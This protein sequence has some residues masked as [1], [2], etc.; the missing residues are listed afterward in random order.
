MVHVTP[1]SKC[2]RQQRLHD[3]SLHNWTKRCIN[4]IVEQK[5]IGLLKRTC[6][7]YVPL[8]S[9]PVNLINIRHDVFDETI[10]MI[11]MFN[12]FYPPNEWINNLIIEMRTYETS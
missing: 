8:K 3:D 4:V 10:F 7:N 6:K 5:Y 2:E 12:Y 11:S 9:K 1:Q